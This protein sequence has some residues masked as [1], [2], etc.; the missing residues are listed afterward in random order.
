M[1]SDGDC[2]NRTINDG[3]CFRME[4]TRV[5]LLIAAHRGRNSEVL[6]IG[7]LSIGKQVS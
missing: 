2:G 6:P 7:C 1:M 3:S 4:R 5:H